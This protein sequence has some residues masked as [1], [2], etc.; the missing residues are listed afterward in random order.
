MHLWYSY[1]Q[2]KDFP[3]AVKCFFGLCNKIIQE[4]CVLHNFVR[5]RDGYAFED[6]LCIVGFQDCDAERQNQ[7][8]GLQAI[9]IRQKFAEYFMSEQGSLA[10]QMSII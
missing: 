6:T 1:K 2:M 10:W 3:L 7:R 8:G 9:G 4:C 5:E